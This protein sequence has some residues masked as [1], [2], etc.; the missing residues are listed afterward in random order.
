MLIREAVN[1]FKQYNNNPRKI[2]TCDCVIRA[3]SFAS[4]KTWEDTF[5]DLCNI[6]LQEKS[7]PNDIKV[8]TKYA[9]QLGLTKYKIELVNGKRP[10]VK[11]FSDTHQKG[12]FILR[13][14]NHIT[15]V[16]DGIYYDIWDCGKKSVYLYWKI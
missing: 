12:T 10:T 4:G 8:Y 3:F 5:T 16:K 13:L 14:A 9:E 1:M 7:M 2:K 15:V 11:S 6:A